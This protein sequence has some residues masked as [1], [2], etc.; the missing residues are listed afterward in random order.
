MRQA[1]P[2]RPRGHPEKTLYIM[3]HVALN[4]QPWELSS[5]IWKVENTY[6]RNRHWKSICS[7][8]TFQALC[9]HENYQFP[10]QTGSRESEGSTLACSLNIEL[11]KPEYV[12]IEAFHAMRLQQGNS[13]KSTQHRACLT[14]NCF[15]N[16]NLNHAYQTYIHS[17]RKVVERIWWP[18]FC[19]QSQHFLL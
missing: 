1:H 13:S 6:L 9:L 12:F 4:I 2:Q 7:V 18:I 17:F 14:H 19:F 8:L 10:K 5:W 3:I 16:L 15:L 11:L